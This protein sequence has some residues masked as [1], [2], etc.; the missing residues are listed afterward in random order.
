MLV[1]HKANI[2][3]L[4]NRGNPPAKVSSMNKRMQC[5]RFLD[6]LSIQ[7]EVYNKD[8]V[9]QQQAKSLKDLEKRLK[10][11]EKLGTG[12]RA[13]KNY[14]TKAALSM[15]RANSD[16]QV[17]KRRA[18]AEEA[19]RQNFVLQ[20]KGEREGPEES[21]DSLHQIS[22]SFLSFS[23]SGSLRPL[24]R[25]H[26]GAILNNLSDLAKRPITADDLK[27]SGS[28]PTFNSTKR[29]SRDSQ[30]SSSSAGR[31]LGRIIPLQNFQTENDSEMVTFLQS[32]NLLD[33]AQVMVKER[34]DMDALSLCSEEDLRGIGLGLGPRLKIMHALEQR[35]EVIKTP[36]LLTDSEL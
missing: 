19:A 12:S 11:V 35:K 25:H 1:E 17:S 18:S 15:N 24:P 6:N 7:M 32:L 33:A 3:A 26:S 10:E 2:Y 22:D 30:I 31:A 9:K 20:Q 13:V 29:H 36:P 27:D 8:Y 4:D 21:V 16:S 5:C 28:D 34:M 14:S 23:G